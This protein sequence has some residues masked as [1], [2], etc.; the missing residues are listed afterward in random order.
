M[1]LKLHTKALVLE[2]VHEGEDIEIRLNDIEAAAQTDEGGAS[3]IKLST[4][5]SDA[6][7]LA[8]ATPME[9]AATIEGL[10]FIREYPWLSQPP[11]GTPFCARAAYLA[12]NT[13]GPWQVTQFLLSVTLTLKPSLGPGSV[14]NLIVLL[15]RSNLN[16]ALL[17]APQTK[18]Q[19]R[20]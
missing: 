8:A 20:V 13:A 16:E 19:R 14:L 4:T 1:R 15:V 17:H 3:R 18:S 10:N 9:M 5:H 7:L 6:L 12:R 11:P 2:A